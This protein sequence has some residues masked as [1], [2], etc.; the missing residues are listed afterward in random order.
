MAVIK[1]FLLLMCCASTRWSKIFGHTGIDNRLFKK[2]IN[3]NRVEYHKETSSIQAKRDTRQQQ[4]AS[5]IT[6]HSK[7]TQ[8]L[9]LMFLLIHVDVDRNISSFG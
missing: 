2:C 7:H 1:S 6:K 9:F 4:C 5:A 3:T 8:R